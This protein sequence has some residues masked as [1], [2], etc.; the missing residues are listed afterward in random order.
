MTIYSG[1]SHWKWW[2]SIVMLVYQRVVIQQNTNNWINMDL[3][4]NLLDWIKLNV[5]ID[6]T[7]MPQDFVDSIESQRSATS[8]LLFL[9]GGGFIQGPWPLTTD[10]EGHR[11]LWRKE[12][13]NVSTTWG[14]IPTFCSF[15]WFRLYSDENG[16]KPILLI[17]TFGGITIH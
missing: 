17:T 10:M 4:A 11:H 15:D 6:S 8:W 16:S 12:A 2:F 3:P 5:G 9:L 1:I 7:T 13:K 14:I